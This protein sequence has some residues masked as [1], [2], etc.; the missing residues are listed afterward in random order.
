M[1]QPDRLFPTRRLFTA[2]LVGTAVTLPGAPLG[3]Q[4]PTAQV[5]EATL[6]LVPEQEAFWR[7]IEALCG[8]AFE[9]VDAPYIMHVRQ[10]FP[11]EIRI[12]VHVGSEDG[13]PW[14]RSRTWVVTR[15]PEG[16]RL[17]HD[18][19]HED[20]SHDEITQYGGDT[21]DAGSSGVQTFPADAYTQDVI[22]ELVRGAEN[23]IWRME[24]TPGEVFAYRLTRSTFDNALRWAFDLSKPVAP[25]PAPWGYEHEAPTH[26]EAT[27][28]GAP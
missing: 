20:G 28:T 17:K 7:A 14:N 2:L 4:E 9:R 16:L 15:T 3:A 19:R 23:N 22:G 12:P 24:I 27:L 25:P 6:P 21:V 5:H 8:M 18:H 10:C 1:H 11:N 26:A 13:E